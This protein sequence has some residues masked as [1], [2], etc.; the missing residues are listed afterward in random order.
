LSFNEKKNIG[1]KPAGGLK[2]QE[3][4]LNELI[5]EANRKRIIK[6]LKIFFIL[7]FYNMKYF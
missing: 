4:S 1:I 2:A 6:I 3:L 7:E 5:K